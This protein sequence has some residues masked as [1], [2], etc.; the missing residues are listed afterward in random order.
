ME[1]FVRPSVAYGSVDAFFFFLL[2]QCLFEIKYLVF[3]QQCCFFNA[4]FVF[5][6]IVLCDCLTQNNKHTLLHREIQIEKE[7]PQPTV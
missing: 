2:F 6:F 1:I 3:Y 5:V 4:F 7:L